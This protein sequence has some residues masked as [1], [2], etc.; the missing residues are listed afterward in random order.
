MPLLQVMVPTALR[1]KRKNESTTNWLS[2]P[3]LRRTDIS[4]PD[5]RTCVCHSRPEVHVQRTCLR[6][7][8]A[9]APY[10]S[11]TSAGQPLSPTSSLRSPPFFL[12]CLGAEEREM[13]L[14]ARDVCWDGLVFLFFIGHVWFYLLVVFVL[15]FLF[16][17]FNGLV[18][19]TSPVNPHSRALYS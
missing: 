11:T 5:W 6:I 12:W 14:T 10:D 9:L 17:F 1:Q 4:S 13:N 7:A 15:L 2:N 3:F 19:S 18:F 8:T 16:F